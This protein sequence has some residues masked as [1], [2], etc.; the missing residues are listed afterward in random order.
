MLSTGQMENSPGNTQPIAAATYETPYVNANGTTAYSTNIGGAIADGKYYIYNTEHSAT[1]PI[2][3]GWQLHC[4]NATT[5]EGIWKVGLPGG[6]SKHTTD[7][8]PIADGYLSVG[9]SDGYMYVYGKGKTVTTV[10][11]PDMLCQRET[12]S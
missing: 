3:R 8:G 6:G 12:A 11:A 1:V 7:I 2:T 10:T 9:G 4:I 5:G